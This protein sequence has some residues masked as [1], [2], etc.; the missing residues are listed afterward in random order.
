MS[1]ATID[2]ARIAGG[3]GDPVHH[4]QATFRALLDAFARPGLVR[5]LP[6]EVARSLGRPARFS[7]ALAAG[8]LTLLDAETRL[9]LSPALSEGDAPTWCRFHSGARAAGAIGTAAFV[10]MRAEEVEAE[11]LAALNPGTDEAP[12][13]AATLIV[14]VNAL[15]GAA[16]VVDR[17]A[18]AGF[19]AAR[20]PGTQCLALTGPGIEHTHRLFVAGLP[21]DFW[22]A[23]IAAQ[24]DYPCGVDLLLTCGT[25]FA[26]IP[27][28]T[29]IALGD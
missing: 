8:V 3:F 26:A 16:L 23:R 29:R 20:D 25:R 14:E 5:A 2:L 12:H 7:P 1:A 27:R 17:M 19:E 10:A 4:A 9:W 18:L 28:S 6:D 13:R 15:A 24:A 21:R 22:R 11:T